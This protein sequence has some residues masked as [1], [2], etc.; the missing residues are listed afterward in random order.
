MFVAQFVAIEF[1]PTSVLEK[2]TPIL[3]S[4]SNIHLSDIQKSRWWPIQKSSRW[5]N[6]LPKNLFVDNL[7]PTNSWEFITPIKRTQNMNTVNFVG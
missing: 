7:N 6:V 4:A 1:S 5:K 3:S 2:K